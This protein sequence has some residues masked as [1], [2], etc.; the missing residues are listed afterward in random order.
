MVTLLRFRITPTLGMGAA[1][2]SA[3]ASVFLGSY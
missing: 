1:E 3:Q 2:S